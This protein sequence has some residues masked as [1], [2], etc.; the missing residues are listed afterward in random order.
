M[1]F[2]PVIFTFYIQDVLKLK[3]K[4]IPA[5]KWQHIKA[6]AIMQIMCQIIYT[7]SQTGLRGTQRFRG[8]MCGVPTDGNA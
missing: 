8:G 7:V 3:K 1:Y 5:P 2:V 4:I 6:H